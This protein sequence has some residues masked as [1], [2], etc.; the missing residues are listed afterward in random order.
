MGAKAS[1]PCKAG[2]T[3]TRENASRKKKTQGHQVKSREVLDYIIFSSFVN[4]LHLPISLNTSLVDYESCWN[5]GCTLSCHQTTCLQQHLP[6]RSGARRSMVATRSP[7]LLPDLLILEI[8][9]ARFSCYHMILLEDGKDAKNE[10]GLLQFSEPSRDRSANCQ[11]PCRKAKRPLSPKYVL[12]VWRAKA[13]RPMYIRKFILTRCTSP[14]QDLHSD[15]V[16]AR[17][18]HRLP[19]LRHFKALCVTIHED[20]VRRARASLC[21]RCLANF[22]TDALIR[23]TLLGCPVVIHTRCSVFL[24]LSRGELLVAQDENKLG[25]CLG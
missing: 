20:L 6:V 9:S 5:G 24:T 21:A 8:G 25:E 18:Y 17:Q 3:S 1:L 4:A 7:E 13:L 15:V 2:Q 12:S 16:S 22:P 14:L 19:D 23:L 10:A 11:P